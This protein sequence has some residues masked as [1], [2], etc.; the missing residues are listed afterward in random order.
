MLP[1]LLLALLVLIGALSYTLWHV[2][3]VLPLS[4]AWRVTIVTLFTIIVL[5]MCFVVTPLIDHLPLNLATV[6][7]EVGGSGPMI[8]LYTLLAFLLLDLGRLVHLVPRAVVYHNGYTAITITVLLTILFVYGNIHYHHKR[9]GTITLTTEKAID[10]DLRVL[11]ISDLHLGYHNRRG[12]L[13][14][15][16]ELLNS[17]HADVILVA[18]DIVDRSIRPLIEEHMSELF[19]ELNAPVYACLGNHEYYFDLPA[20]LQFY[21]DAGIHLLQDSVAEVHG[22]TII[23][24]DDRTNARRKSLQTLTKGIPDTAYTIVLDHQPWHLEESEQ[25]NID[26]QFSGHTHHGQ[27]FP[28]SLIVEAVYENAYGSSSRGDTQYYVSSGLGI[29]GGKYRIGTCSEYVVATIT[30]QRQ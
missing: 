10:K 20:A 3:C 11:L 21:R 27:V 1:R 29:W 19:H 23:G 25:A 8:M 6:V 2:W 30:R 14:R 17:E 18:G 4:T 12:T 22:L 24:R 26:F 5:L 7:Y 13:Q 15:W 9:R 28:M 16:I